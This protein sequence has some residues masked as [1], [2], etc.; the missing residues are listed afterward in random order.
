MV[1]LA[2]LLPLLLLLVF[3]IV[4]FA[5]GFNYKDQATQVANEAARWFV[6]DQYPGVLNPPD[7]ASYK[8]WAYGELSGSELKKS[9]GTA[10]NIKICFTDPSGVAKASNPQAGDSVTVSIPVG[11]NPVGYVGKTLGIN[12]FNITGK[13]TMRIELTPLHANAMTS[14]SGC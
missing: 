11:M 4:D 7:T 6:V 3:G 13:A 8:S 14:D 12:K 1:E 10:Q 9:V 5:R 2:L